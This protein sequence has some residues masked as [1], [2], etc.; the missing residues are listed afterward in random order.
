MSVD[1][2]PR[3]LF[4]CVRENAIMVCIKKPPNIRKGILRIVIRKDPRVD[5]SAITLMQVGCEQDFR[6]MQIAGLNKSSDKT[7]NDQLISSS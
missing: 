2:D 7:D 6:M 4:R 5:F 3:A 1:D